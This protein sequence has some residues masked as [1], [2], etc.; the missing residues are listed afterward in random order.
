LKTTAENARTFG[1]CA[2]VRSQYAQV[3]RSG[4]AAEKFYYQQRRQ[5][6]SGLVQQNSVW[7]V[8]LVGFIKTSLLLA[9]GGEER[10]AQRTRYVLPVPETL[11]FVG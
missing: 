5:S 2:A 9:L 3:T 6:C 11:H 1:K 4:I 10:N 8:F 7:L